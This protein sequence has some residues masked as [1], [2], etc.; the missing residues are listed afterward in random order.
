MKKV[1][2]KRR[3]INSVYYIMKDGKVGETEAVGGSVIEEDGA[4]SVSYTTNVEEQ[5]D[6][7]LGS[8][9][10]VIVCT[11][12]FGGNACVCRII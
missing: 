11:R 3:I 6:D 2:R 4:L 8:L 12:Y 7:M 10:I 9:N 1:S 5:L